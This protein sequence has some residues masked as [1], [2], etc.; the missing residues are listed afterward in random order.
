M[1][2]SR[3]AIRLACSPAR[4]VLALTLACALLLTPA[5]PAPAADHR[6]GPIFTDINN[7][8][9]LNDLY[10]FLDPNDNSRVV[11]A[12]DV[13][14]PIIPPE[15]AANGFFSDAVN[16]RL[17][18]ENTGD[19]VGDKFIDI[20]FSKQTAPGNLQL[21]TVTFSAPQTTWR[22]SPRP[23]TAPTTPS[24]STAEVAPAPVVTTDPATGIAVFAGLV[25]DP[26]F[27]DLPALARYL[28]SRRAGQP[29][30]SLLT[31]GRDS[32]AGYNTRMVALSI[33]VALLRGPTGDIVGLSATAQARQ[34]TN[35]QTEGAFSYSGP[36]VNLDRMGLPLINSSFIR[37]ARKDEYNRATTTDDAAGRFA[38][39]LAADLRALGTNTANINLLL[40]LAARRGDM[41]RLNLA[42]PNTGAGGG[43]NPQAAFPNGRRPNDDVIDTIVTLVH[44]NVALGD[45]V[46]RNEVVFRDAFPFFARPHQPLP[47]GSTDPTQN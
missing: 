44:N 38:A 40:D 47:A 17:Q 14:G 11:V 1:P 5:T 3:S 24:S 9:D 28:D 21:A 10:L 7:A 46:D 6:D 26:F 36:F 32:F 18:F 25:E 19:A 45:N 12:F 30:P 13:A 31:R 22:S 2:G 27:A 42:T 37:Y 33:P 35:Y 34:M 29:D 20:Q 39:D 23:F 43:A 16:Y 4:P 41:L 15:N 8:L